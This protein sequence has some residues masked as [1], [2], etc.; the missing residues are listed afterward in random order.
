MGGTSFQHLMDIYAFDRRIR[1]LLSRAFERIEIAVKATLSGEGANFHGPFWLCDETNFDRGSHPQ[2][3]QLMD[4]YI[5]NRQEAH[6]H[7]FINHFM[8]KYANPYP[9]CWMMMELFSFGAISKIYK[10]S[11]GAIRQRVSSQ[12]GLQHDV[13]ESWLHSLSFARNVCAHHGRVWNRRF[14]IKPKVPRLYNPHWP[15]TT[16]DRLYVICAMTWHLVSVIDGTSPWMER[17]SHL[18]DTRPG[19]PLSS[20]GFPENWR[21]TPPWVVP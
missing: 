16:H 12:F 13:L 19:V 6:Q 5:G 4:E 8:T 15:V 20:M 10:S 3:R 18:I 21:S 7:I 1:A 14:T 11:K 2:I 17:L 9:P